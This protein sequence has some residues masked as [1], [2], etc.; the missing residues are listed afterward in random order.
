MSKFPAITK[1]IPVPL[2]LGLHLA[3]LAAVF[4]AGQ[5]LQKLTETVKK[6]WSYEMESSTWDK[7]HSI[8]RIAY[9]ELQIPDVHQIRENHSAAV[10]QIPFR[11]AEN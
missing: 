9:P 2:S 7:F 4:Y 6:Q 5:Q 3:L 10:V 8:N 11:I 1:D